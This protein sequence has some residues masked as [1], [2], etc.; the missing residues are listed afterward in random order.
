[1]LVSHCTGIVLRFDI[2][3]V[4]ERLWKLVTHKFNLFFPMLP[5]VLTW[6][7]RLLLGKVQDNWLAFCIC[8][9]LIMSV[10]CHISLYQKYGESHLCVILAAFPSTRNLCRIADTAGN[11][12]LWASE[13]SSY[14]IGGS[15]ACAM[16]I[17]SNHCHGNSSNSFF[18][19]D[20]G[21]SIINKY[22]I[23]WEI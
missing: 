23:P 5:G 3:F 10:S 1:M 13:I 11:L 7:N 19:L 2:T 12:I 6:T 9:K 16:Y 15:S 17:F 4:T 22:S 8:F 20:Q 21:Q 14:V 18:I